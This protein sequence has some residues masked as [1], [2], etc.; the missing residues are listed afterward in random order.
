MQTKLELR[1]H[2]LNQRR[3]LTPMQQSTAA[4]NCVHQLEQLAWLQEIEHA[5]IYLSDDGEMPTQALASFL[6][7]QG[8]TCYLPLL[9]QDEKGLLKFAA[10][11]AQTVLAA[12]RYGIL[13]PDPD[14]ADYRSIPEL[15]VIFLPLLGFDHQGERLGRGA[16]YYDKSL[17][18][19]NTPTEKKPLLIGLGYEFQEVDRLPHDEWDVRLDAIAT[20]KTF[21]II[22]TGGLAE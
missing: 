10:Y 21:M 5:G 6:W 3:N 15:D 16:G 4:F 17:A 12:N 1:Q 22:D 13:E 20:D 18:F 14:T 8:K 19:C 2:L 7:R 11:D 9:D